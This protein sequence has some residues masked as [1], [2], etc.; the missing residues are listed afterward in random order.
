MDYYY[1]KKKPKKRN[2][3]IR[4]DDLNHEAHKLPMWWSVETRRRKKREVERD[5]GVSLI[6]SNF[7]EEK[8][9]RTVIAS[10]SV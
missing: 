3:K 9:Y 4:T 2:E 1:R 10:G 5:T 7:F 8:H 6:V